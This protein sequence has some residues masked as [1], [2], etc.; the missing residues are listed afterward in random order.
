MCSPSSWIGTGL[1]Q[2]EHLTLGK[3]W[4]I[5]PS[6]GLDGGRREAIGD[7]PQV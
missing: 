2:S 4:D 7:G 5:L 3:S 6:G 1:L